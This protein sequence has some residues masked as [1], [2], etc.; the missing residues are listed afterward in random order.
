M[1]Y[2]MDEVRVD[3]E[4]E[5]KTQRPPTFEQRRST[6]CHVL[7]VI[8][9]CLCDCAAVLSF[10]QQDSVALVAVGT[11]FGYLTL[12]ACWIVLGIERK[13]FWVS[14]RLMV[15]L[16]V[17]QGAVVFSEGTYEAEMHWGLFIASM[18]F[19]G[20]MVLANW[21]LANVSG[22]V[23]V[24]LKVI[25]DETVTDR[26][27][28]GIVELFLATGTVAG[29]IA[30][31]KL[32]MNFDSRNDLVLV[33]LILIQIALFYFAIYWPI[34]LAALSQYWRKT[35]VILSLAVIGLVIPCESTLIGETVQVICW[36]NVPFVIV[37]AIH[38]GIV[39]AL[40]YQLVMKKNELTS[41]ATQNILE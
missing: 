27:R 21:I 32:A 19:F 16:L 33:L 39:N 3:S 36:L 37:V 30:L 17:A 24:K 10:K 35:A 40:G 6:A 29:M 13:R 28:Y 22:L 14:L 12:I 31:G 9:I 7:G 41:V 20:A 2:N 23:V 15:L 18:L 26:L 1:N 8:F 34:L 5:P 11:S 4:V 25:D 38:L